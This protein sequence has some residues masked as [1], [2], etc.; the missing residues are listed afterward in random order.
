MSR[1][2]DDEAHGNSSAFTGA[3]M[4]QPSHSERQVVV[5]YEGKDCATRHQR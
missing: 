3:N 1:G 4:S 5:S 2:G